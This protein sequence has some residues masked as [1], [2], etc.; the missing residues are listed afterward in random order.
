[1]VNIR[2]IVFAVAIFCVPLFSF[3]QQVISLIPYPKEL[4]QGDGVLNV[5]LPLEVSCE[6]AIWENVLDRFSTDEFISFQ[7][8]NQTQP[9]VLTLIADENGDPDLYKLSISSAGILISAGSDQSFFYAIQSL[10][11]LILFSQQG[12]NG[13]VSLPFLQILDQPRYGWRGFMLD[14]S[15]HFFG[16]NEVKKILDWMALL[17]LN[18]FHWHL[19]D[20]PGWRIEIK[21]Y[22]LLT[23]VGAIGNHTDPNAAPAYYTQNEIKEIIEY[24]SNLHIDIIP[25]IDMPG[26]ATAAARAY[27][28][29]SGGGNIQHPDFTFNPGKEQTYSFLQD[30]LEEVAEIF[31]S[32]WIHFGG[33]E[34]HFA[35]RQ[36]AE[37]PEVQQLMKTEGLRNLDEVE[38]YFNRRMANVI[39]VLGKTVIGWE[40]VAGA[41]LSPDADKTLL[42]WWRHDKERDMRKIL[43]NQYS[44]ILTPRIPCYFDFVQHHSHQNGRRWGGFSSLENLYQF[45]DY[46]ELRISSSSESQIQGIQA[47]LWTETVHNVDRLDFMTFPRITALAESAWSAAD[48]KDYDHYLERLP[49][50]LSL[51]KKLDILYFDPFNPSAVV[52]P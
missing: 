44:I 34:V 52:E 2:A 1:M 43:H 32:K 22:P 4:I 11:Q 40:E 23:E 26:H 35:N 6:Q 13:L 3:S 29:I 5:Q 18:R 31:P 33:D 41:K 24:A 9:A 37:L 36:W 25:E 27:P 12:E 17:K 7:P 16:M 39:N 10:K 50:W 30:I 47:S 20:S 14:E 38:F 45:P 28:E 19:T 48:N 21:K 42:M 51:M 15:R 49:A 46:K 8:N